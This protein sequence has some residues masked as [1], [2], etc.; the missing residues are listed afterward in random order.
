MSEV[1]EGEGRR[2]DASSAPSV[3]T[4]SPMSWCWPMLPPSGVAA[5]A[6]CLWVGRRERGQTPSPVCGSFSIMLPQA[7]EPCYLLASESEWPRLGTCVIWL[8]S[9]C[10]SSGRTVRYL[11]GQCVPPPGGLR[12]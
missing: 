3:V 9:W 11:D 8:S 4:V 5:C 7:V 2:S 12:S 6:V 10:R 1:G